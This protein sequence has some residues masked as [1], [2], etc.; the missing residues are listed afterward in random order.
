MFSRILLGS[1]IWENSGKLHVMSGGE[2]RWWPGM[3]C[4]E[5][6]VVPRLSAGEDLPLWEN[7]SS[8]AL[9]SWVKSEEDKGLQLHLVLSL[10]AWRQSVG[11]QFAPGAFGLLSVVAFICEGWDHPG[12]WRK[13]A[14][15]PRS[16]FISPP[17]DL[18]LVS[19][20]RPPPGIV[21]SWMITTPLFSPTL[22]ICKHIIIIGRGM[23]SAKLVL[24]SRKSLVRVRSLNF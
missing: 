2:Q 24:M 21:S 16:Q 19:L 5:S 4:R 15:C 22:P 17:L 8:H 14:R 12:A 3:R 10:L 13:L 7:Q 18:A 6:S 23:R 1:I 11:L 9:H 20:T